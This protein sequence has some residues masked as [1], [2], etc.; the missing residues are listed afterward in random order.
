MM[1]R[2]FCL[3]ERSAVSEWCTTIGLP[4]KSGS[5]RRTKPIADILGGH[6]LAAQPHLIQQGQK[7]GPVR[8]LQQVQARLDQSAV[9]AGQGHHVR[10]GAHG[11]KVAAVIQHLL[12]RAAVQRGTELEGHTCAAQ[13]LEGA[14]TGRST[15]CTGSLR[16]NIC[17]T[18][19]P[20]S[21]RLLTLCLLR[22]FANHKH[23]T[24]AT[25]SNQLDIRL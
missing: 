4:E 10:H 13:A 15:L 3:P 7:A 9:L 18:T 14:G 11:G 12:G 6:G 23:L 8:M 1:C 19:S 5:M 24:R 16:T 20:A 22:V 2:K 17:S 21:R 25:S